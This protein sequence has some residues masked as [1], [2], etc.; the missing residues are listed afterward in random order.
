MPTQHLRI[1][2]KVQG[3]YFRASAKEMADT[4]GV[5]GWIRNTP[6]GNVEALVCGAPYQLIDFVDWCR[7]GPSGAVV[8]G[9]EVEEREEEHFE[10]FRIIR[11]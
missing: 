6:E 11:G 4:L 1:I 2:G 9:F 7:Q 10:D 3:V 5:T 8:T